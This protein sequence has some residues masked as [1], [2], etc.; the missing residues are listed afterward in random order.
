[1]SS[2]VD[3]DENAAGE[4]ARHLLYDGSTA[5]GVRVQ[6]GGGCTPPDDEFFTSGDFADAAVSSGF[7]R[8]TSTG[9][10]GALLDDLV[11]LFV[12]RANGST[13]SYMINTTNGVVEFQTPACSGTGTVLVNGEPLGEGATEKAGEDADAAGDDSTSEAGGESDTT[14]ENVDSEIP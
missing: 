1:M 14:G 5:S 10:I 4:T 9:F 12:D 3:G 8:N 13:E 11:T 7:G 2:I 6:T